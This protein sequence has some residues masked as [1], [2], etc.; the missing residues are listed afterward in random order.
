MLG[1]TYNDVQKGCKGEPKSPIKP[2]QERMTK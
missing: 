2:A 1:L